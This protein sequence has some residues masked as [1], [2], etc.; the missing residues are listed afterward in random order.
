[1]KKQLQ[2]VSMERLGVQ[3]SQ[4]PTSALLA[5]QKFCICQQDCSNHV[6]FIPIQGQHSRKCITA[7][8]QANTLRENRAW[9]SHKGTLDNQLSALTGWCQ[10][11]V[12]AVLTAASK[13][14]HLAEKTETSSSQ[15]KCYIYKTILNRLENRQSTV[16][17]CRLYYRGGGLSE[18]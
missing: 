12:N 9:N 5:E 17:P 16:P 7:N 13:I 14:C 6:Y 10:W 15:I 3:G 2:T 11:H 1:M 18:A 4:S 8:S